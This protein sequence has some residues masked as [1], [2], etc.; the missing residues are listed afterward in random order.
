[1]RRFR[2][3]WNSVRSGRKSLQKR[4]GMPSNPYQ[5]HINEGSY[6]FVTDQ[7]LAYA[8]DFLD[9]THMLPPVVGIYDIQVLDFEFD[10]HPRDK[11]KHDP[12]VGDTIRGLIGEAFE[13]NK[14]AVIFMCD[15]SDNRARARHKLFKKWSD[16]GDFVRDDL[17]IEAGEHVLVG[18]VLT[19]KD[20]PHRSVL[21]SDVI[22]PIKGFAVQKFG[23]ST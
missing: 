14:R 8:C 18:S 4:P 12:R 16:D 15:N 19:R 17:E 7:N 6:T 23:G 13:D 9:V 3:T 11:A 10:I 21:E 5:V 20:F 1:M 22:E 2:S